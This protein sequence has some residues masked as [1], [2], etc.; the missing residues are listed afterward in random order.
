MQHERE[1]DE[2]HNSGDQGLIRCTCQIPSQILGL[3]LKNA[4][5]IQSNQ[6]HKLA[7]DAAVGQRC[8]ANM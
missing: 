7:D 2:V 3:R 4:L 6:K 5:I 1:E 8:N